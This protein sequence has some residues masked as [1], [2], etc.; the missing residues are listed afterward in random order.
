[1]HL[2]IEIKHHAL[3]LTAKAPCRKKVEF[4]CVQVQEPITANPE[5]S[6]IRTKS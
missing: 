1:M 2:G 3:K 5:L 6:I 4:K